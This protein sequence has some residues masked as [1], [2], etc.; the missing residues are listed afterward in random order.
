MA[1]D[2]L[3]FRIVSSMTDVGIS[4]T[5]LAKELGYSK[6]KS[7]M[8]ALDA[9]VSE[10][11]IVADTTGRFVTYKKA[12]KKVVV[13]ETDTKTTV[14]KSEKSDI[15]LPEA[16][17]GRDM[18][19]YKLTNIRYKGRAAKRITT[20]DGRNIR[21]ETDDKLLVIND[22]PKFVVK[23]AEDV[24]KCIRK[25]ALDHDMTT[26]TVN[27]IKQNKKIMNDKDIIIKD[28]HVLF[29]S[30]RKHNKAA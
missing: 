5:A 13:K 15:D 12:P 23:T 2:N 28:D 7:I 29:L 6:A 20:P 17:V 9:C 16:C 10:G 27:D 4:A 30:I 8:E 11:S 14:V 1:N 19:G 25:Y 24:I 3:K 18:N 22:E 21:L 26:F